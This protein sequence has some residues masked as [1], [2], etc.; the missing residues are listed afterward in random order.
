MDP[1]E[2]EK[3][4]IYRGSRWMR[5][6]GKLTGLSPVPQGQSQ[7]RDGTSQRPSNSFMSPSTSHSHLC[8]TGNLSE[9]QETMARKACSQFTFFPFSRYSFPKGHKTPVPLNHRSFCLGDWQFYWCICWLLKS[10]TDPVTAL[11]YNSVVVILAIVAA[12]TVITGRGGTIA[13]AVSNPTVVEVIVVVTIVQE[14]LL[15]MF[16]HWLD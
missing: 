3:G 11:K 15:W 6:L 10:D 7:W 16:Q 4:T 8:T 13:A 14:S 9:G 5:R 1:N 2:S 12:G